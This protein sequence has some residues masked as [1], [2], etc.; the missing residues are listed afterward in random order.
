MTDD[1]GLFA[2][3][4]DQAAAT[5]AAAHLSPDRRR[6][7]RQHADI[8]AGRHPLTREPTRPDLG[9]CG[10]CAHR[11]QMRHNGGTYPKCDRDDGRLITSGAG[12]DVR[13]H[14]PACPHHTPKDTP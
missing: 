8:A 9:T 7:A 13:A 1:G 11:V 5:A 6:T 4:D 3:T 14:W 12:S 10:D 2:L